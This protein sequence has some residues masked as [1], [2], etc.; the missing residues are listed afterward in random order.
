[1]STEVFKKV[2]TVGGQEVT[3]LDFED[4]VLIADP[5]RH[6]FADEF[7][8]TFRPVNPDAMIDA[9]QILLINQ[10]P[11]SAIRQTAIFHLQKALDLLETLR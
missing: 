11:Y 3:F 7:S 4:A 2:R 6:V 5:D 9:A 10:E 8:M 1:M